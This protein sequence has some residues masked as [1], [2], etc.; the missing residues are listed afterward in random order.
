MKNPFK[1]VSNFF[2]EILKKEKKQNDV[3]SDEVKMNVVNPFNHRPSA[4]FKSGLK[5]IKFF[6]P[7]DKEKK[8][9]NKRNIRN[10]MAGTSRN[11]NARKLKYA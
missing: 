11:I 8:L 7:L 6:T 3:P 5:G 4:W 10:R 1:K 9:K 2:K